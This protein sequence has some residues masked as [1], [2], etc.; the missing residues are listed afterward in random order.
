VI[1]SEIIDRLLW[2]AG[3]RGDPLDERSVSGSLAAGHDVSASVADFFSWMAR[4]NHAMNGSVPSE[5]V[6]PK[7]DAVPRHVAYAVSEVARQLGDTAHVNEAWAV[8]VAWNATLA[9]D[10]DDLAEHIDHE[11]RT[12]PPGPSKPAR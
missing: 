10:I 1:E 4:L 9:G 7:A 11:R 5:A 8:D 2:H 6:G 12:N 3:L